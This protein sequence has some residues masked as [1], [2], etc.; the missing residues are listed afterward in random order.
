MKT[1]IETVFGVI[2]GAT[3]VDVIKQ[4]MESQYWKG[5]KQGIQDAIKITKEVAEKSKKGKSEDKEE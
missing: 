3:C 1:F 5:R 4:K 2:V